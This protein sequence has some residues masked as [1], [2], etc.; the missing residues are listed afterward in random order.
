MDT[1]PYREAREQRNAGSLETTTANAPNS[2]VLMEREQWGT[3]RAGVCQ[4]R[5][6]G[7][8]T[9]L[10]AGQPG[11]AYSKRGGRFF[12]LSFSPLVLWAKAR[13]RVPLSS[14]ARRAKRARSLGGPSVLVHH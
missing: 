2:R 14:T 1:Q 13:W 9:L 10:L 6:G 12:F 11:D 7:A 5:E 8:H 4:L 3:T